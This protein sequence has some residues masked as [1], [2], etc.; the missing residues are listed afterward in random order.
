[1]FAYSHAMVSDQAQLK[2]ATVR[3]A[4]HL[5]EGSHSFFSGWSR[6]ISSTAHLGQLV[7]VWKHGA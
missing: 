3:F 2:R 1:M 4:S 5:P 7:K 6:F